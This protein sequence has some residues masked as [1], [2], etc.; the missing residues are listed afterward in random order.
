MLEAKLKAKIASEASPL[1][2]DLFITVGKGLICPTGLRGGV[3]VAGWRCSLR[4]LLHR[5][6][7]LSGKRCRGQLETDMYGQGLISRERATLQS[8]LAEGFQAL[9]MGTASALGTAGGRDESL[10]GQETWSLH[11]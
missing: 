2:A 4:N 9:A 1:C 7:S 11:A 10:A 5:Y 6:N 8:W 3:W